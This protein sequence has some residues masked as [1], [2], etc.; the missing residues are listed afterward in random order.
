MRKWKSVAMSMIMAISLSLVGCSG[1][2]DPA[3]ETSGGN[4]TQDGGTSQPAESAASTQDTLIVGRGGDSSALDMSIVTDG[5]SSKIG[6]QI[7]ETLLDYKEGTTEVVPALA[8]TYEVSDDGLTYTFKLRQGVKFHDGTDF[9]AE[10]VVFNFM[11]W[12]DPNS[13][14]KFEGDSFDYYNSMFGPPDNRVIKEVK[15]VDEHTVQFVLNKPQAPFLQNV[16][17]PFFGIASPTAIKEKKEKFKEEPVGTGPFMFQEWKRNDS[18]TLVKN[19]NYWQEGLPKLEKIIVRSIPDNSARLTALQA[20]EIDLMEGLNPDDLTIVENNPDLQKFTRPSFNVGY[21]GFNLKKKPFDNKLV[22][23]ALN[24][25]VNKEALIQAF[26]AGQAIPAVNPMPPVLLGYNDE[27]QDYPYDLE[28]AKELLAQA[29]YPNG[30]E[31]EFVFYAMPVPRPY[32]PNGQKVAEA[33][34]AEFAKIGVKTRIESPEWAVYLDDTQKGEKDHIFMLGW[35]GDNGDPDNFLYTLLDKDTIGSNN[36][37]FYANDELH[38]ILSAAQAETNQ[39]KR[40]ELYKQAQVIIK[41]D[42][43]WIP[44]VHSTPLL[45]GKANLKGYVP[46]PTGSESYANV[47]FE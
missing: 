2:A 22:R 10:A 42:A 24:H 34:Q 27:I 8:E 15:A 21:V 20:G 28:K 37:S 44:L 38:E 32:M 11:R 6:Q 33:L 17:M 12:H 41:E 14:Y 30:F 7:Y 9:N 39:D 4:T 16:A 25:A 40:A 31:E 3:Q 26:Y 46:S 45:A 5:E 43:P 35:Q 1:G 18:I 36:Y 29:G 19:P 13:E 23:Q 47:Y